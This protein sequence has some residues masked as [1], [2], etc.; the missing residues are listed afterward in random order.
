M[1]ER[2]SSGAVGIF[3]HAKTNLVVVGLLCALGFP[4]Y[5][6][7]WT[8]IFP[9]PYENLPLRLFCSLISIPWIFYPYFTGRV[10][11][12]FPVYFFATAL[13]T[14]PY[15]FS[16]MLLKSAFS[17]IWVMSTMAG[18]F[19][20]ILLVYNWLLVTSMMATGFA[21][22]YATLVLNGDAVSFSN[23]IPEYIP[24]FAFALGGG[25]I[26]NTRHHRLQHN[27]E[28]HAETLEQEVA[29]RTHDLHQTIQDLKI[30]QA[31]T[32][33]AIQAKSRFFA[34]M[35]HELKN[36]MNG[37]IGVSKLLKQDEL[38]PTQAE[39]VDVLA[40]SSG[41]LNG[42]LDDILNYSKLESGARKV[43]HETF[44][45]QETVNNICALTTLKAQEK[46][47]KIE[48]DIANDT[49][50]HLS[51]DLSCFRQVLL[52]LLTNAVKFSEQGIIKVHIFDDSLNSQ[53]I[54]LETSVVDYG[55]GIHSSNEDRIFTAFRQVD[56]SVSREYDG[57]G[58]GLSI[59]KRLLA[60]IDG[61]IDYVSEL[62]KGSNFWFQQGFTR[63]ASSNP[64]LVKPVQATSKH[65]GFQRILVVDDNQA[66]RLTMLRL[67]Q[68]KHYKTAEAGDGL[69][70]LELVRQQHFDVILMDINMPRMNGLEAT[71]AIRALT[72]SRKAN[73]P[74]IA[75]TGNI[76]ES[77]GQYM[78][79]GM[80]AI[81][82]KPFDLEKLQAILNELTDKD[83]TSTNCH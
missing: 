4:L 35:S 48:V 27:T 42:L 15:F 46:G 67:L 63:A 23:F 29:L 9:Q 12:Y 80:N 33:Q 74:V 59:C 40:Q 14:M 41:M 78:E 31:K 11:H 51:G 19:L 39:Y 8:S 64:A 70:A 83:S 69:A 20:L 17:V 37:I 71:Q 66:G 6:L 62:G 24:I 53:E 7:I 60:D 13:I 57:A 81:M 52:N 47:L 45:L 68:R 26:C 16:F 77:E 3:E 73:T 28:L 54:K 34:M 5:Y 10:K 82:L 79:A 36:P 21:L 56:E 43:K 61:E 38:N 50:D 18:L 1:Q 75:I 25:I 58:L 65:S 30:E 44:S 22:A 49:P 76:E 2:I 72:D 32:E 55:I